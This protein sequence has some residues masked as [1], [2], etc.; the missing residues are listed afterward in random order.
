MFANPIAR[1]VS[2]PDVGSIDAIEVLLLLHVPPVTELLSV[3]VPP[4]QTP[5]MPVIGGGVGLTVN[6]L[7]VMQPVDVRA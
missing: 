6:T 2:T 3:V 7:V 1:P 4:R 5:V